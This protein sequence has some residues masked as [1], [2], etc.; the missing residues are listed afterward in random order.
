MIYNAFDGQ[1]PNRRSGLSK[2][3]NIFNTRNCRDLEVFKYYQFL[4]KDG[5]FLQSNC[6]FA[7]Q[8]PPIVEGYVRHCGSTLW[9]FLLVFKRIVS[10]LA[11][12]KE[13]IPW[14][15]SY[16]WL[17]MFPINNKYFFSSIVALL[18]L[19]TVTREE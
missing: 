8:Q 4:C 19:V 3:I 6:L 13:A 9:Q 5:L 1:C 17:A 16:Q 14:G 10:R 7:T 2:E 12:N 18:L 15:N 11:P